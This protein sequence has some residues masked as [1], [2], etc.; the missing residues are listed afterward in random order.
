MSEFRSPRGSMRAL[1]AALAAAALI[2]SAAPAGADDGLDA[3]AWK[4]GASWLSVR[5]G[6]ARERGEFSPDGNVG[7]GFGYRRMVSDRLS[8]GGSV[9]YDLLGKYGSAALIALPVSLEAQWHFHWG[10]SIAPYVGGGLEAVYRKTYRS[11]DDRASFQPGYGL[12]VGANAPIDPS[13]LIGMDL[14]ASSV[15]NDGWS[16]NP[17]FGPRRPTSIIVSAKLS[18]TLTY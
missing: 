4:S 1:W 6:Y 11:G 5:F 16:D 17:S 18:Y 13:H 8:L 7:G 15:A 9:E 3:G 14:R 12:L 10:P 2:V